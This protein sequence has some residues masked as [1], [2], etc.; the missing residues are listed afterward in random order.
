MTPLERGSLYVCISGVVL[1]CGMLATC[2]PA[3]GSERETKTATTQTQE[4]T[5]TV[6][7]KRATCPI[8]QRVV[9]TMSQSI[10]NR[11]GYPLWRVTC[12]YDTPARSGAGASSMTNSS[13]VGSSNS[14][15]R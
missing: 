2:S 9:A 12:I 15:D 14:H 10:Y 11:S 6:S 4:S 1:V 3:R 7:V 8:K 13:A 5:A